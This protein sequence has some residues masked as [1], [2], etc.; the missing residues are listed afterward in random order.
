M[1][2]Y[3]VCHDRE[4]PLEVT[5]RTQALGSLI[6]D[7]KHVSLHNRNKNS[8]KFKTYHRTSYVRIINPYMYKISYVHK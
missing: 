2:L 1:I 5:P 3:Q 4:H 8:K 7:F 6:Q